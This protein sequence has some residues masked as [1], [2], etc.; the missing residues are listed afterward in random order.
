MKVQIIQ[1]EFCGRV[2]LDRAWAWADFVVPDVIGMCPAC[3]RSR[4]R[5]SRDALELGA[6]RTRELLA[7]GFGPDHDPV[8]W[9][10]LAKGR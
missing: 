9:E 3:L 8:D 5:A 2:R 1:C 6:Q 10:Q 4:V 7:R